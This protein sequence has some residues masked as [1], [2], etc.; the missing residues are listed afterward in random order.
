MDPKFIEERKVEATELRN[1]FKKAVQSQPDKQ[2]IHSAISTFSSGIVQWLQKCCDVLLSENYL[3]LNPKEEPFEII[4]LGSFARGEMAPYS[5]L[6][7]TAVTN[8]SEETANKIETVL[9]DLFYKPLRVNL[10]VD[11]QGNGG[12]TTDESSGRSCV[13]VNGFVQ[14]SKHY[15]LLHVYTF[16]G[17]HNSNTI[18]DE[19]R[20][21]LFST[22][23]DGA[24]ASLSAGLEKETI[25]DQFIK[26]KIRGRDVEEWDIKRVISLYTITGASLSLYKASLRNT[27]LT[28][29]RL[30]NVGVA[31]LIDSYEELVLFRIHFQFNSKSKAE[32]Q[33]NTVS[34]NEGDEWAAF[35]E[36]RRKII[37]IL[38]GFNVWLKE[39]K[40]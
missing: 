37:P 29:G 35:E 22:R 34:K 14:T 11:G 16:G 17:D 18:L 19:V 15:N 31:H 28:I 24:R 25:Y 7:I 5:D 6:D 39:K 23:T 21:K 12:F 30:Q 2:H 1:N 32:P 38:E 10:K 27:L 40:F 36:L 26:G 13:T 4:A 8:G 20:N 33:V 9:S 3:H